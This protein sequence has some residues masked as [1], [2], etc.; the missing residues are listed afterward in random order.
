[1]MTLLLVLHILCE[2][3]FSNCWGSDGKMAVGKNGGFTW[4]GL[5]DFGLGMAVLGQNGG[6]RR[7]DDDA[8]CVLV[9]C[10]WS[11]L[12]LVVDG[13]NPLFVVLAGLP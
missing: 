2:M 5:V 8:P 6:G 4:L 13:S 12:V 10:L 9:G 7:G 3:L 11:F 1:M